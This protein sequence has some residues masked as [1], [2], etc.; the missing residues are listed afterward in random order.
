MKLLTQLKPS[1]G[2]SHRYKYALFLL[3]DERRQHP[4]F[5]GEAD[6]IFFVAE[7]TQHCVTM[8]RDLTVERL[9]YAVY[10]RNLRNAYPHYLNPAVTFKSFGS[11]RWS[12]H[13]SCSVFG[14]A[15]AGRYRLRREHSSGHL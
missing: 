3:R 15:L 10:R 4:H 1:R 9:A 11:E 13:C 7:E 12:I 6:P 2:P 8:L 14:T 5:E